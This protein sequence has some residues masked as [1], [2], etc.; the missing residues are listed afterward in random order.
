MI[1]YPHLLQGNIAF[2]FG[3]ISQ[4]LC[5]HKPENSSTHIDTDRFYMRRAIELASRAIGKTSPNPC[6]GCVLV[7]GGRII[8]EGY[9]KKAGEAHAEVNALL[10]AGE[11]AEGATAYV[12]LEPCNHYGR[13]PPCTQALVRCV[14]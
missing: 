1:Q 5:M 6:V 10:E 7:K 11:S 13:T 4:S 12:S 3:G 14:L 9:H 2:R 8:G